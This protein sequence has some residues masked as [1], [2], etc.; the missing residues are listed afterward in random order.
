M[1]NRSTV[2][3]RFDEIASQNRIITL[4]YVIDL[5]YEIPPLPAYKQ[6]H[7]DTF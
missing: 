1:L 2:K 3:H 4:R 5:F 6:T 7:T